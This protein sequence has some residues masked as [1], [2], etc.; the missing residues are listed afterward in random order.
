M[1][2]S[3]CHSTFLHL[4]NRTARD[5]GVE[6]LSHP[7]E[8]N[9]L[10]AAEARAAV[11]AVR[12]GPVDRP[13][14]RQSSFSDGRRGAACRML[15]TFADGRRARPGRPVRRPPRAPLPPGPRMPPPRPAG[16]IEV[17]GRSLLAAVLP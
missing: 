7:P 16:A 8:L 17:D 2:G 5:E 1:W 12:P 14:L 4:K 10:P 3:G 13:S 15:N 11:E 6:L 9:A